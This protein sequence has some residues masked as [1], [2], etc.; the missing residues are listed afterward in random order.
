MDNQHYIYPGAAGAM[1]GAR[2]ARIGFGPRRE[3]PTG[4]FNSV[5]ALRTW[6][7]G[8]RAGQIE[9]Y[10]SELGR[11]RE[12]VTALTDKG[13]VT[14]HLMS[15]PTGPAIYVVQRTRTQILAGQL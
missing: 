10:A 12:Y 15:N 11:V 14:P 2:V 13:F 8:A 3:L 9:S 1:D 5:T 6:V 4:N 7:L